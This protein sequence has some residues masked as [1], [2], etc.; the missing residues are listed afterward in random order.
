MPACSQTRSSVPGWRRAGRRRA[1]AQV[2]ADTI[3][4][5]PS[6]PQLPDGKKA[7]SMSAG[8]PCPPPRRR[9]TQRSRACPRA[10]VRACGRGPR[11]LLEMV[12]KTSRPGARPARP[13]SQALP[14]VGAAR[15]PR[16]VGVLRRRGQNTNGNRVRP[17]RTGSQFQPAHRLLSNTKS[18]AD[19]FGRAVRLYIERSEELHRI[20]PHLKPG[21]SVWPTT[22]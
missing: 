9:R 3:A 8:R 2:V 15:A 7:T 16:R 14:R 4:R 5:S 21:S 19:K 1:A 22:R 18:Q 17:S 11:P 6:P 20:F 10:A 12:L 13:A